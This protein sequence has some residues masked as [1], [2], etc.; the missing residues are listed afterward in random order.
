MSINAQTDAG[1]GYDYTVQHVVPPNESAEPINSN[2]DV[3]REPKANEPATIYSMTPVSADES[4]SS[5]ATLSDGADGPDSRCAAFNIESAVRGNVLVMEPEKKAHL[6]VRSAFESETMRQPAV[7]SKSERGAQTNS[8]PNVFGAD[9]KE[10]DSDRLVRLAAPALLFHNHDREAF[11]S[12]AVDGNKETWAVKSPDFKHWLTHQYWL[13]TQG[14]PAANGMKEAIGVLESKAKFAG[15]TVPVFTRVAECNGNIYFDLASEDRKVIEITPDGWNVVADAPVNFRRS[16]GMRALPTPVTGGA[17]EELRPFLNVHDESDWMLLVAWLLAAL[18][19][20]GPYP[21]AALHG[22]QGSAKTTTARVLRSLADPN[23]APV[24]CES[25]DGRDLMIS[26]T[27]G[28]IFALDNLSKVTDSL[29][30]ALCRLSTGGGFATRTLHTDTDETILEAQRPVILTGIEELATRGDLLDRSLVINLP[31]IDSSKRKTEREF[32]NEFYAAQ[33]RI[34]GALLTVVAGTLRELPSVDLPQLPRMADFAVWVTAA[35]PALGWE[36]GA[37]MKAFV[38]NRHRANDVALEASFLATPILKLIEKGPWT[39]TAEKLLALLEQMVPD[40]VRR[41]PDW[42]RT[43]R[44]M[45]SALTRLSPNLRPLAVLISFN[46]D[47]SRQRSR[48][49]TIARQVPS[50]P[51]VSSDH[52][53]AAINRN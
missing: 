20:H 30:D 35:E 42:P 23:L 26:A 6:E 25:R 40:T 2:N 44:G 27:N 7:P 11:A 49:I 39:G 36:R 32:W 38:E 45:S 5:L 46:R 22:E 3:E 47:N 13:E 29:S 24:R 1:N 34:L 4:S 31:A 50:A 14:A 21:L 43:P 19:P 37:F 8:I 18:R 10:K 48:I 52:S 28:W 41:T 15:P 9:G 51:S 16:R 12:V 33:P 17:I 53:G